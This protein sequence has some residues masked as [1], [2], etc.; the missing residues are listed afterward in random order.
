M[1]D[2]LEAIKFAIMVITSAMIVIV[3][4]FGLGSLF[5]YLIS[6]ITGVPIP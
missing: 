5:F 4:L 3:V 2:F 1:N 6:V